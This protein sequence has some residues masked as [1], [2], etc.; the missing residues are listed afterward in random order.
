MLASPLL[1]SSIDTYNL[2]NYMCKEKDVSSSIL[3]SSFL[4]PGRFVDVLSLSI[5]KMV[6][7]ILLVGELRWLPLWWDSRF[8][9]CFQDAFFFLWDTILLSFLSSPI[10]DGVRFQYSQILAYYYYY[11]TPLE[12]FTSVL[13]DG[14]SLEFER[15]QVPTSLL[16]S[17]QGSGRS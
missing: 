5:S 9:A 11:F 13:A 3:S 7:R 8:R 14:F 4:S 17:S 12:F 16:D 1:I 10:L 2:S 6:P 15:Q